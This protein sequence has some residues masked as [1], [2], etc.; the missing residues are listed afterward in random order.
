MWAAN[1]NSFQLT[2]SANKLTLIANSL[3]TRF[4]AHINC[5]EPITLIEKILQPIINNNSP[6]ISNR[7]NDFDFMLNLMFGLKP[8]NMI[9]FQS[10]DVLLATSSAMDEAL[11]I[12]PQQKS[13]V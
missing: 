13:T 5:L 11:N 2:L 3:Q 9:R 6:K 8:D 4:S 1:K 7:K 12:H 10:L